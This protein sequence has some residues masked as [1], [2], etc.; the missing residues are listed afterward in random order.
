MNH[1]GQDVYERRRSAGGVSRMRDV[2]R[3]LSHAA[4]YV[5]SAFVSFNRFEV[6]IERALKALFTRC[7][8]VCVHSS[9]TSNYSSISQADQRLKVEA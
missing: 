6:A 3:P 1:H 5:T 8:C 2:T 9:T 7:V 4:L